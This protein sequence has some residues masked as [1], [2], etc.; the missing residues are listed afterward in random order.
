MASCVF[1]SFFLLIY[2]WP[3]LCFVVLV[4]CFHDLRGIILRYGIQYV[5]L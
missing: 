4:F 1:L 2:I 5:W 3:I